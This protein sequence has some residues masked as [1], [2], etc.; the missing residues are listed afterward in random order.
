MTARRGRIRSAERAEAHLVAAR[1]AHLLSARCADSGRFDERR[2]L[3]R[4]IHKHAPST[5]RASQSPASERPGEGS[6]EGRCGQSIAAAQFQIARL[7]GFASWPKLKAYVESLGEIG[8][9]KSAIDR[10]DIERVKT[11]M[12]RNPALHR[13]PL[14]YGEGRTAHMGGRVSSARGSTQSHQARHG[15]VDDRKRFRRASRR[16]TGRSCA[17]HCRNA[18]Q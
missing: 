14:G 13:A 4:L 10:D 5:S 12:T 16:W 7:Y 6:A 15:E 1:L 17:Q 8:Q 9:L 18:F 3:C 11:M 2:S